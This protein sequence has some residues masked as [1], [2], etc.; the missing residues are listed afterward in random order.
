MSLASKGFSDYKLA[1]F[2]TDN[3]DKYLSTTVTLEVEKRQLQVLATVFG[4]LTH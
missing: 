4:S 1:T 3:Q 2:H